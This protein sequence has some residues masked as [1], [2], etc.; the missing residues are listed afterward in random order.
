MVTIADS[1]GVGSSRSVS[2]RRFFHTGP[3]LSFFLTILHV[4]H[5]N[6]PRTVVIFVERG[7][8]PTLVPFPI[9]V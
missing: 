3:N 6:G 5:M 2:S 8:T 9:F 1:K 7:E 4:V